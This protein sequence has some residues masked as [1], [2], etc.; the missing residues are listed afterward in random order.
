MLSLISPGG[1][2]IP[3]AERRSSQVLRFFAQSV[4]AL[5]GRKQAAATCLAAAHSG[6]ARCLPQGGALNEGTMCE[7]RCL[8][9]GLTMEL[10]RRRR[11]SAGAND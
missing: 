2:V 10:S 1:I 4:R 11:R 9:Q 8:P 6:R 7:A 5:G 3:W